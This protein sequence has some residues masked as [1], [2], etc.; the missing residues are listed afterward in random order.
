M[1]SRRARADALRRGSAAIRD[2]FR[3]WWR[4]PFAELLARA[5]HSVAHVYVASGEDVLVAITRIIRTSWLRSISIGHRCAA[6]SVHSESGVTAAAK[7][8]HS[9]NR[10]STKAHQSTACP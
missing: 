2:H 10:A 4:V 9:A 3:G 8:A 7:V 5:A 6:L 1:N